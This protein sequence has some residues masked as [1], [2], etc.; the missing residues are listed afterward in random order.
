MT[1]IATVVFALGIWGLFWLDRDRKVRPSKALWISTIWLLIAGSRPISAW[2]G[3]DSTVTASQMLEGSPLDRFFFQVLL[4]A[5]VFVLVRRRRQTIACLR[6]NWAIVLYFC[7]CLVSVIWSDFP[8]V[9][10]KRW[11]KALGD[12]VMVLIVV[13]DPKPTL[14]LK[15]LF[16]R[17]GFIL[18]PVSVLLIKYFGDMGRGYDP[19]GLSSITGVTT[20]KNLLGVITFLLALTAVWRILTLLRGSDESSPGR[21]LL[22]QSA[23]LVFGVVLLVMARSTTS[24]ACFALG[25]ALMLAT[26]LPTIRRR[27][28]AVHALVMT[29]ALAGGLTMFFVGE[30]VVH[31]MGKQ[32]D[33]TGRIPIWKTVIPMVPNPV[34]GAGFESFWLGPRLEKVWRA[35]P[36]F[37]PNEAHNGYI[38]VYLNLGWVGVGLIALILVNGYMRAIATFRRNPGIGGLMLAYVVAAT[39]YGVTEAGFRL[40]DPIWIFLLLAVVVVGNASSFVDRR[41]P[42]SVRVPPDRALVMASKEPLALAPAGRNG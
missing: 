33:F 23:L 25:T 27:P 12:L 37:Q 40:L 10:F 42:R 8:D 19:W 21:H 15:R 4:A 14:A 3:N 41:V 17:T 18:L 39:I 24:G 29:A 31:A 38:E 34:L 7:Y 1:Q 5:G 32:T 9:A 35:F 30:D 2:L 20:N 26:G 16:S 28:A 11:T 36:V 22:A 13:T 6:A